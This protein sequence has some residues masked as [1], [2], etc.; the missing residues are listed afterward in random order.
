MEEPGTLVFT[1]A[2]VEDP[3]VYRKLFEPFMEHLA[4]VTGKKVTYFSVH[5]NAAEVE[6]MRSG[7]LH[8]AGFSTGPRCMRSTWPEPC[9]SPA[10]ASPTASSPRI[11]S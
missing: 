4:K 8:I 9:R 2:P 10:G 7:R 1:Y 6:A 11:S 3:G 5:S